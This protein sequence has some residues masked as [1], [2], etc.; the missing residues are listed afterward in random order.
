M[1]AGTFA[2]GLWEVRSDIAGGGTTRVI[3]C[4]IQGQMVLLHGFI[5]RTR[6]IPTSD[7]KLAQERRWKVER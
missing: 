3:L 4:L 7:I 2:K 1:P 5:N 6:K